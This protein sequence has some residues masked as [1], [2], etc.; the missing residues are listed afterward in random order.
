MLKAYLKRPGSLLLLLL[1][2]MAACLTISVIFTIVIYIFVNGLMHL[3]PQMFSLDY[4]S[5]NLSMLPAII[6]TVYMIVIALA[7]AVPTGVFAA[8]Y[9]VEYADKGSGMIK[10]I[11]IAIETLQGIPSIVYGIFGYIFFVISL[12]FGY[13]LISGAVTLAVMVLPLIIRT[14]E[15]ALLS[16][17]DT[18]REGSFGLGAGRLQTVFKIVLPCAV[19]GISAGIILAIGRIVGESAALIFTSGT[20]AQIPH[21]IFDSART[22]SVHMYALMSEGLNTNEAYATAVV[23]LVI[24]LIINGISSLLAKFISVR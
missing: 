6:T 7:L 4:T 23:L 17:P 10:V 1:I 9:L 13:S 3:S 14:T 11:R 12:G 21:S 16:V 5:E 18:Y 24:V 22:L 20:V 2:V 15:E 8:I 19:P